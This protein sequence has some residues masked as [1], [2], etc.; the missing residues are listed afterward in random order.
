[1]L[2]K[3]KYEGFFGGLYKR[4][5]TYLILSAVLLLVSILVGYAFAGFLTPLIGPMLGNFKH[6]ITS[7]QIQITTQSIFLNNINVAIHLYLGGLIIGI[8]TA[9]YIITNG[10]FIGYTATQV[11]LGSFLIY[12]VP[13]GIFELIGIIIAGAAGFRLASCVL[14]ILKDLTHMRSDISFSTQFKYALE[15]H[16]DEFWESLKLMAVAAVFLLVAAFIEANITINLGN[17]ITSM[18]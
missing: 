16:T 1:M 4:N 9:F 12:T 14:N 7:G 8:G 6:Q 10:A 11:P 5:E 15:L 18:T 2:K 13:H 3:E 17:Y